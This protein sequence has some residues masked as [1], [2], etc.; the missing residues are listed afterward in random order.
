MQNRLSFAPEL[1]QFDPTEATW[2]CIRAPVLRDVG[3]P[4]A[5]SMQVS[6]RGCTKVAQEHCWLNYK[7]CGNRKVLEDTVQN[8]CGSSSSIEV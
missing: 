1:L 3:W 6:R 7:Q 2:A 8:K 4:S 5:V